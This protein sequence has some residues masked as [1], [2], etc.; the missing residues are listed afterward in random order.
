LTEQ[1]RKD[2]LIQLR[3]AGSQWAIKSGYAHL[4]PA[5]NASPEK[6]RDFWVYVLLGDTTVKAHYDRRCESLKKA[7]DDMKDD[8]NT[9][10]KKM[11]WR[12]AATN[13]ATSATIAGVSAGVST[14]F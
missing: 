6:W 2:L 4:V 13:L 12:D 14:L 8:I 3:E 11:A 10:R 9:G 7:F 5:R 1:E